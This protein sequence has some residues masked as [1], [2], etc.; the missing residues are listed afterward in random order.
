MGVTSV[1]AGGV[2]LGVVYGLSIRALHDVNIVYVGC[3]EVV[4][5]AFLLHLSVSARF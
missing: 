1:M 3:S 2:C 4:F 5:G